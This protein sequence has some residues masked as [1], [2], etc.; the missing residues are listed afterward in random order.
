LSDTKSRRIKEGTLK[1]SRSEYVVEG[2]IRR[3]INL[4]ENSDG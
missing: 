3:L 2:L 1:I 4:K